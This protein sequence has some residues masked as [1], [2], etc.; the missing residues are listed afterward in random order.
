[1]AEY[2]AL[3][4]AMGKQ[5]TQ[6][7]GD[8]IPLLREGT[9]V[10]VTGCPLPTSGRAAGKPCNNCCERTAVLESSRGCTIQEEY[11]VH[12]NKRDS[13]TT[14][15][16]AHQPGSSHCQAFQE[17]SKCCLRTIKP[18]QACRQ[19]LVTMRTG[20]TTIVSSPHTLTNQARCAARNAAHSRLQWSPRQPVGHVRCLEDQHGCQALPDATHMAVG[21]DYQATSLSP[22]AGKDTGA[23]GT[24]RLHVYAAL[25]CTPPQTAPRKPLL[26]VRTVS[27][28]GCKVSGDGGSSSAPRLCTIFCASTKCPLFCPKEKYNPTA[29]L[30]LLCTILLMA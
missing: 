12:D 5:P 22:R 30:Q 21:C 8:S 18:G 16:P 10:I 11:C 13:R 15:W 25:V 29:N 4:H 26:C 6:K 7:V 9:Q 20:S 19:H 14:S 1:M 3:S 28:S 24:G 17:Q 2:T 27:Q 23:S